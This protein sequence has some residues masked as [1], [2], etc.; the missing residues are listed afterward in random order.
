M[1]WELTLACDQ[2]CTHCGSRAA[3]ARA[4]ELTTAEALGVVDE[5]AA[6]GT[7]E[8]ALIG[9]EAYLHPGVLDVVAAA[10]AHAI[11]VW[12]SRHVVND[13]SRNRDGLTA[14]L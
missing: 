8:L 12:L 6:M 3:E 11:R 1:V 9:G 2:R 7:R 4:D 14:D 5:L 10:H 13:R